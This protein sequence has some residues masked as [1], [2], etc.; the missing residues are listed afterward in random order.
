MRQL[1]EY[2]RLRR[3]WWFCLGI[4]IALTAGSWIYANF[5]GAQE[6]SFIPLIL[7]WAFII[8]AFYI[9]LWK[10]RQLRNKYRYS[11]NDKSKAVR[12][13]QKQHA[14]ELR[15]RRKQEALNPKEPT[16][17]FLDKVKGFFGLTTKVKP[18]AA[19]MEDDAKEASSEANAK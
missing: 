4:S 19:I 1:P 17:T 14:A 9:D 3:I 18:D 10:I 16:P 5:S 8:V 13:Q 2:K 11:V 12:A 6:I 7:A 15:E